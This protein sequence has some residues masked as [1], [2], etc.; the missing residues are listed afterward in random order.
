MSDSGKHAPIFM[1]VKDR[2]EGIYLDELPNGVYAL[3][4]PEGNDYSLIWSS[5]IASL[6][7]SRAAWH[8]AAV[9]GWQIELPEDA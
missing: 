2:K 3:Y 8:N 5:W 4:D 7:T 1:R 9:R 6:S